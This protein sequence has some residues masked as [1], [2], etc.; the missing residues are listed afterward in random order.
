MADLTFESGYN[1]FDETDG[2]HSEV[3][4]INDA[5]LDVFGGEIGTLLGFWGT[6]TGNIYGGE[7]NLLWMDHN[8]VVNVY[9]GTFDIFA[10]LTQSTAVYLHAFDVTY[11]PDGGLYG[12][13][14]FE[15]TYYLDQSPFSISFYDAECVPLVTIVPE[16]ATILLL[17]IGGLFLRRKS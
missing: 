4:V 6:S 13:P 15:G 17:A 3:F 10:L 5:H 7:I 16:P 12:Q 9:G 1:V 8:A 11:H 14:W 2:Y